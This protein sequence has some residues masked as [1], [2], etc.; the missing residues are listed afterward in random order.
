MA[1]TPAPHAAS[2]L[3]AAGLNANWPPQEGPL[4]DDVLKD[5]RSKDFEQ[6]SDATECDSI[7]KQGGP[8]EILGLQQKVVFQL[9]DR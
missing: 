3:L 7:L 1:S 9:L 2:G 5:V 6:K 8:R 4:E